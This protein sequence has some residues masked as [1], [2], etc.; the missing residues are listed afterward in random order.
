MI[1]FNSSTAKSLL[2]I[3]EEAIAASGSP[4]TG[5]KPVP[6]IYFLVLKLSRYFHTYGDI[7]N[8]PPHPSPLPP[9]G[10]EGVSFFHLLI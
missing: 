6:P 9:L 5:W 7:Q 4:G 2:L 1:K 3:K 10:G 8:T